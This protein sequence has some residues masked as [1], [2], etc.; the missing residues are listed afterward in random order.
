MLRRFIP[1]IDPDIVI[2][3]LGGNDLMDDLEFEQR[4]GYE[5][6]SEGFPVRPAQV[7]RLWLLQKSWLVR[8][9]YYSLLGGYPELWKA[10]WPMADESVE[11]QP[12]QAL[13]C[14]ATPESQ[15]LYR[16]KTGRYIS[17]LQE[18]TRESEAEFLVY[19]IH[20]LWLFDDEPFHHR[21][22]GGRDLAWEADLERYG[23][24]AHD[25]TPYNTF[26]EGYLEESKITF[27][28]SYK[29]FK[30]EKEARP[31]VKLWS[32]DDYHFSAAGHRVVTDDLLTFIEPSVSAES[33]R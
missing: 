30:R 10:I 13:Y 24:N 16:E 33:S 20:Y 12:W 2:L 1:L 7:S 28:N 27:H 6:D 19:M 22:A 5:R 14:M 8:F 21:L 25:L 18:M 23:C 15:A 4:H 32:Y 29:R 3:V 31:K 17:K 11:V 9:I 26:V